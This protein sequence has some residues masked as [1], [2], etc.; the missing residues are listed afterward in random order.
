MTRFSWL[1]TRVFGPF[2]PKRLVNLGFGIILVRRLCTYQQR[3][4]LYTGAEAQS[5]PQNRASFNATRPA[6][7]DSFPGIGKT[8]VGTIE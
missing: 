7:S 1:P 5:D 4:R 2:V 6:R 3:H 8:D